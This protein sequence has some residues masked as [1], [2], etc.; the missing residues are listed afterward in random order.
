MKILAQLEMMG[1]F[2]DLF[3]HEGINYFVF[4][5]IRPKSENYRPRL[6]ITKYHCPLCLNG[7]SIILIAWKGVFRA[8]CNF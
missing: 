6:V 5:G 2:F 1:Q 8:F 4:K 7:F 3:E